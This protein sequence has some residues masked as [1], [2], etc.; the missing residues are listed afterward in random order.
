MAHRPEQ[1]LA[2]NLRQPEGMDV[3]TRR[4]LLLFELQRFSECQDAALAVA[5]SAEAPNDK[6][7]MALAMGWA[8]AH[9]LGHLVAATE[10]N[11]AIDARPAWGEHRHFADFV[12]QT[13]LQPSAD[14]PLDA[15]RAGLVQHPDSWMLAANLFLNL[16]VSDEAAAAEAVGLA[17]ILRRNALLKAD[18]AA[19]LVAAHITLENWQ[20]AAGEAA[21]ALQR[22]EAD[23]RL[24]G[25]AAIAQE[26]LGRTGAAFA[27]L[28][29]ALALGTQRLPA[30]YNYMGLSL[31]LGRVDAVRAALDKLLA[32]V[33]DPIERI[34]LMRLSTLVYLQQ[35]KPSEALA[36]VEALGQ[37]VDPSEEEQEGLFIN[38]FMAATVGGS[39]PSQSLHIQVQ[40]RIE[41][42]CAK[43]PKSKL[44]RLATLPDEKEVFDIHD[45]LGPLVG[46]SRAQLREFELRERRASR[47]EFPVPFILRPGFV[48]HYVGSPFQLWEAAMRSRVEAQQFHLNIVRQGEEGKSPDPRR[49]VP[50][51]D[52]TTLLVLDSLGLFD[53]LFEVFRRVAIPRATVAFVSHHALG[54]LASG[55]S[56]ERAKSILARVNH[57]VDRIDQPSAGLNTTEAAVSAI[58]V[59]REYSVLAQRAT[60]LNYCD[61]VICRAM[62]Q[63]DAP[64]ALSCTTIDFLD[65]LD[66]GDVL[67]EQEVAAKLALLATWN[68]GIKVSDRFLIASLVDAWPDGEAGD[69]SRRADAFREHPLFSTLARAIWNP[70][71]SVPDLT[72]DMVHLLCAMLLHAGSNVDSAAAVLANWFTRVRLLKQADGLGWRL[73]CY[74]VLMA[75]KAMPDEACSRLVSVLMRAVSASVAEHAMSVAVEGEVT[76]ALG[77]ILGSVGKRDR[78]IADDLL[79]KLHA[80]MPVGTVDGDRLTA[81][82]LAEVRR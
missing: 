64:A 31:R 23:D 50:L 73:L 42:F 63:T 80:A 33:T 39:V 14:S 36:A 12:R 34:E 4:A 57:W 6:T 77:R 45:L 75:I 55:A 27:L 38:V 65:L 46:D 2:A 76:E 81:A 41:A 10:L 8:A 29:K 68:V 51:L 69:A 30:I 9:R 60:W 25:M 7:P 24:L 15:L 79:Q 35:E 17:R 13:T 11:Q 16:A 66:M 62:I 52:L 70:G 56:A 26:M 37:L 53:H 22:F 82:Y 5:R 74:P 48:L 21:D 71:K 20:E 19:R 18:E 72:N 67:A 43:W 61:D 3:L 28:E 58:D 1:A 78:S 47:G 59:W 40:Q 54:V 49:E 32:L 44:F